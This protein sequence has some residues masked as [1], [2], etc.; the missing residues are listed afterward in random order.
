MPEVLRS[1]DIQK[2]AHVGRKRATDMKNEVNA[3]TKSK[4]YRIFSEATCLTSHFCEVYGF[5]EK[6]IERELNNEN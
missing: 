1:V 2:V 4:G 5:K 3:Y 6:N